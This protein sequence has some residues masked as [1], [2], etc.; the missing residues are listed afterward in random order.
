M[1]AQA[2]HSRSRWRSVAVGVLALATLALVGCS[3]EKDSTSTSNSSSTTAPATSATYPAG[4][5]EVCQ[6]RDELKTSVQALT[7]PALLTGGSS[8]I[9]A[10]VDDVQTN[11]DALKTAAKQ[12][13]QP[14]V[15]ALQSSLTDLET[16]V[17]NLGNGNMSENLQTVGTAIAAVGTT[18]SDL[19]TKLQTT[20]GS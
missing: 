13:Y 2:T 19:F 20:C 10:A 4:K 17:G 1:A 3:S 9:K 6:A 7:K 12:D 16:A 8:A 11:L 5:Q 14:E 15:E 18:S